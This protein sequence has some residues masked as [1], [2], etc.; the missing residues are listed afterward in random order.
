M[1]D[2]GVFVEVVCN[3]YVSDRFLVPVQPIVRTGSGQGNSWNMGGP[4][5]RGLFEFISS[6]REL[7]RGF[8]PKDHGTPSPERVLVQ[9]RWLG[10]H[11]WL[12]SWLWS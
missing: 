6:Q 1:D 8:M 9:V 4:R 2:G 11:M 5:V 12:Y 10:V 7:L 3:P